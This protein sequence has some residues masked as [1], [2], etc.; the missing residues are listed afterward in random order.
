MPLTSVHISKR[1]AS[2][3][4]ATMA[5]VYLATNRKGEK[6]IIHKFIAKKR[7]S[8]TQGHRQNYTRLEITAIQA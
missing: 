7:H 8:K 4:A 1:S 5:Q 3:A 2:V 6:I